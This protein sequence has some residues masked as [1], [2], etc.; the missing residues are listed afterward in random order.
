MLP[1][2]AQAIMMKI[3]LVVFGTIMLCVSRVRA[4]ELS[5]SSALKNTAPIQITSSR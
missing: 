3:L 5:H 2:E 1:E 4:S